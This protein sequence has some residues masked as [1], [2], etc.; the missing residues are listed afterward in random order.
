[1]RR[2]D[3]L[4]AVAACFAA[5]G[6]SRYALAQAV[7]SSAPATSPTAA[8]QAGPTYPDVEAA[9][10]S[11]REMLAFVPIICVGMRPKRPDYLA[12]VDLDPASKSYGQVIHRLAMPAVGDELHH[13][14]WSVCSSCHGEH[15]KY[16]RYL[17]VPGFASGNIHIID[18]ADPR[19]PKMHKVIPGQ[20]IARKA[21]LTAPHTVH[22]A[23][24]GSIIISML[25][26]ARGNAPGGFL[27][28]DQNFEVSGRW[29]KDT[30][31]M[32]ANYDFWYQPRHNIMVSS[33]WAA[34][35]VVS[36][37]FKPI[38]SGSPISESCGCLW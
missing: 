16:R 37:G 21:N 32:H 27:T 12:S 36:Q 24:D 14:G 6:L 38:L 8:P 9:M 28:M 13:F 5:G 23:P 17:V 30:R 11:P 20:E 18:A 22:C 15:G 19:R 26:D 31:G 7:E 33:E 2:R 34:P 35:S 1:M 25:G 29:E 3:F 4:K 10:R